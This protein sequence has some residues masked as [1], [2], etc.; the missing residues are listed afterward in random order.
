MAS[1]PR[2]SAARRSRVAFA[3]STWSG[4]RSSVSMAGTPEK[5]CSGV[6]DLVYTVSADNQGVSVLIPA[7][8]PKKIFRG[9]CPRE[10]RPASSSQP[11]ATN[12]SCG[13]GNCPVSKVSSNCRVGDTIY[14]VRATTSRQPPQIP[15]SHGCHT[16]PPRARDQCFHG[17]ISPRRAG[18][19]PELATHRTA[20]RIRLPAT[21]QQPP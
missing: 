9:Q 7:E 4:S 16:L 1:R 3:S 13:I 21:P 2:A 15:P 19:R 5:G 11:V 8:K 18:N 20:K 6:T 12:S 10:S 17:P 14:T